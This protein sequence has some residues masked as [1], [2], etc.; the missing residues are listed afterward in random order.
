MQPLID[1]QDESA[2]DHGKAKRQVE[3][4]VVDEALLARVREI[5]AAGMEKVISTADK[6]ERGNLYA[7]LKAAGHLD[8]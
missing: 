4:V 2:E 5:A 8:P 1:L 7:A 3:P 6:M